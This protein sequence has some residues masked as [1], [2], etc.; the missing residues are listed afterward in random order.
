MINKPVYLALLLVVTATVPA[1]VRARDGIR[2]IETC[3]SPTILEPRD[4]CTGRSFVLDRAWTVVQK[5]DYGWRVGLPCQDPAELLNFLA[6]VRGTYV[7]LT[8]DGTLIREFLAFP[9]SK[10]SC[11]DVLVYERAEAMA[12][13][14]QFS[15]ALSLNVSCETHCAGKDNCLI[16]TK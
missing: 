8:V 1:E 6:S 10:G 7:R 13:C 5:S 4:P 14:S 9:P 15:K 2:V 12:I 11:G 16:G 3:R